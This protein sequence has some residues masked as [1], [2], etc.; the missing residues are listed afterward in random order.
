MKKGDQPEI[1]TI[2]VEISIYEAA[3]IKK[4]REFKFGTL[5]IHKIQGQPRR[6]ET[7]ASEM[8]TVED[9]L[10]LLKKK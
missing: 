6:I 2:N 10:D 4:L 9:G 3:V 1:K 7:G 8:L 5:T